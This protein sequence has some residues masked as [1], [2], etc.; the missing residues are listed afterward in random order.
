MI[1]PVFKSLE[2]IDGNDLSVYLRP[3]VNLPRPAWWHDEDYKKEYNK[4]L[5]ASDAYTLLADFYLKEED[6][7]EPGFYDLDRLYIQTQYMKDNKWHDGILL[8]ED[9]VPTREVY[10]LIPNKI[11]IN[12]SLPFKTQVQFFMDKCFGDDAYDKKNRIH[13]L[14]E[15]VIE[16]AQATEVTPNHIIELIDHVYGKPVGGLNEEV[17]GV[18]VTLAGVCIAYDIS[19]DTV[20]LGE[21]KRC[22]KRFPELQKKNANRPKNSPLPVKKSK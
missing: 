18:M 12:K 20:G 6:Q 13:R 9:N 5:S 17:G 15:E 10:R 19:M 7:S 21:L 11:C 4:Q 16:L 2:V 14:L 1:N 8:T 3:V 22:W